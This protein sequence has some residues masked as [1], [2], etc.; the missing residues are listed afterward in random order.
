MAYYA[1]LDACDYFGRWENILIAVGWHEPGHLFA[2]GP[3][4]KDFFAKLVRMLSNPWEPVAVAGR[5]RCPFWR[6][7]GGPHELCFEGDTISLGSSNLFVPCNEGVFVAP[8]LIAHY[9]DAHEYYPP[10]HFQEAVMKC[11]EMKTVP[12]LREMKSKGLIL[13]SNI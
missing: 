4:S 12:Y 13:I 10:R 8:S 2:T 9:V 3:V 5:Q 11:A 6:F 7:T 1:D